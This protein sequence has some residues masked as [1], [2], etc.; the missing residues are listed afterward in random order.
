M[1]LIILPLLAAWFAA[2]VY[3][4]FMLYAIFSGDKPLW[5]AAAALGLGIVLALVYL[6][7]G[8]SGFKARETVWAFEIPLYFLL[9]K[10]AI[11]VFVVA[12]VCYFFG[13]GAATFPHIKA[14]CFVLAFAAS[15]GALLG[16]VCADRFQK[17]QGITT[18]Y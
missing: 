9:N 1:G 12:A 13:W 10:A 6:R 14:I 8:L 7:I 18:T 4:G 17:Q 3:S 2:F 16:T 11:A 5:Y 15:A